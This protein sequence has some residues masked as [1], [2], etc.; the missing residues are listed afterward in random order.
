M[1]KSRIK[2]KL[3]AD[4]PVICVQLHFQD[5]SVF[6]LTALLGYDGI[7]MDLEHHHHSVQTAN[8]MIRAA[9]AGGICD[10]VARPAKGE[11]MRMGRLLEAG[12]HGIMYPRCDDAAEAAEVVKW[13]KFAPKGKR[14]FDGGNPDTPYCGLPMDEYM[15]KAND[16]TFL[17]L[18][19]EEQHAVDRAEQIGAVDGVDVLFL[20][21]GDFSVLSGFPGQWDHPK[22]W[23]AYETVARASEKTGKW[24]GTPAFNP[25]H[26]RKLM[27]M[28]ALFFCHSADLVILKQGLEQIIAQFEPLGFTFDNHITGEGKSYLQG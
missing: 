28:G 10:I 12:A 8:T 17:V 25:E 23:K 4:K 19:L 14:G 24:W 26:A 2:T 21:P 9:R 13:M 22:L 5:Q 7:W 18:Q 3:A 27:E 15:K 20:G 16:E 11:F 1:R 6:E